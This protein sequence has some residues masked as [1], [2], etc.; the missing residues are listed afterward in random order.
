MIF[1]EMSLV[2]T[3]TAAQNIFLNNEIKGSTGFI[4]DPAQSA[5]RANCSRVSASTSIRG[6]KSERFQPVSAS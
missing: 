3:L 4:D 1:Q 2:P 5:R 6:R